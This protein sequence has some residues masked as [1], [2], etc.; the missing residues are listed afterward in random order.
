MSGPLTPRRHPVW[1]DACAFCP[2][3]GNGNRLEP[4]EQ[5]VTVL[6][7]RRLRRVHLLCLPMAL[8]AGGEARKEPRSW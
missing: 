6:Y 7:G 1:W 8:A 2:D 3:G 5:T 4:A